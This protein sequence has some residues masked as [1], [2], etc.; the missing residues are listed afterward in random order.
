MVRI[1][2]SVP[3]MRRTAALLALAVPAALAL[4]ATPAPAATAAK[5]AFRTQ[6]LAG[7]SGSAEPRVTVA[8]NGNRFL[9]T[10]AKNGDEVVYRSRDGLTWGKPTTPGNQT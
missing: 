2:R 10:N 7:S 5:P 9:T 6:L 8:P 4:A 3:G 1:G